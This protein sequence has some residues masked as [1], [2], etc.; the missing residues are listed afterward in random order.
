V[1]FRGKTW[2][3]LCL[4]VELAKAGD[5]IATTIGEVAVIVARGA[6]GGINAFLNRCAHRRNRLCL[7]AR[8][9]VKEFGCIYHGWVYDLAGHLT[10]VAFEKRVQRQGGMPLENSARR[11]MHSS[12]C[13]SRNSAASYSAPSATKP[14]RWKNGSAPM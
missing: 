4:A 6:D 11:T 2:N 10:G 13:R 5:Y 9:N 1:L 8:G 12:R 3:D 14:R 7:E